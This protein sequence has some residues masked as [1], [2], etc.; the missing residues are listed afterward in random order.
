[1]AN[2]DHLARLQEGATAWN[3][4]REQNPGIQPDLSGADLI[5]RDLRGINLRGVDLR[6]TEL[7]DALLNSADLTRTVGLGAPQ[8]RGADLTGSKLPASIAES[9][10]KP[11]GVDEASKNSRQLFLIM[12]LASL[13]CWIT[14]FSTTDA[15]LLLGSS[16]LALPIVQTPIPVRAFFGFAPVLLLAVYTYMHF[17]F[18]NFWDA[19]SSL[20]ARFPDGRPLH[21]RAYPW[22][23]S[24]FVQ[25]HF[26]RLK[27]DPGRGL[28]LAQVAL[29]W[30]LAWCVV[31]LTLLAFWAR[32]LVRRSDTAITYVQIGSIAISFWLGQW[33][34]RMMKNTLGGVVPA[35]EPRSRRV[36]KLRR[37]YLTTVAVAVLTVLF[38][39]AA[40]DGEPIREEIHW[41]GVWAEERKVGQTGPGQSIA[42]QSLLAHGLAKYAWT[43]FGDVHGADLSALQS[44]SAK[45][46]CPVPGADPKQNLHGINA[47][48]VHA[49]NVDFSNCDLAFSNFVGADLRGA[50]FVVADLSNADLSAANLRDARL[51]GVTLSGTD[52]FKANLQ[53]A[54]LSTEGSGSILAADNLVLADV[55]ESALVKLGLPSDHRL[56]LARKDL[57]GYDFSK[58]RLSLESADLAQFNLRDAKFYGVDLKKANLSHADLLGAK[59]GC[60]SVAD[61]FDVFTDLAGANLEDSDLRGVDLRD[62]LGLT[63][64]QIDTACTDS[65]TKLPDYL[66]RELGPADKRVSIPASACPPAG[67]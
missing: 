19:L 35:S 32:F 25:L 48:G 55:N 16:S 6:G 43:P 29:S 46:V 41:N 40:R 26:R 62:S 42:W 36:L 56:R 17:S 38:Y 60:R 5:Q 4:W 13:Y 45:Q 15:A 50:K 54:R 8:L 2:P 27:E 28:A 1:M 65:T 34:W 14:I 53:G 9:L 31:P 22:L 49:A 51:D 33:F 47:N 24:S 3:A 11:P 20:P 67:R 21:Q 58:K 10:K 44:S 66:D 52:V 39:K 59:F 63:R 37:I 30:L 18:Q 61:S 7:Q 64:E 12:L 57:S 23:M